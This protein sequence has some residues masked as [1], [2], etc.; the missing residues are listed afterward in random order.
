MRPPTSQC[1]GCQ[2]LQLRASGAR[3]WFPH[4]A[5]QTKAGEGQPSLAWQQGLFAAS[6]PRELRGFPTLSNTRGVSV[7][8][9]CT[10]LGLQDL[11][12]YGSATV[13]Q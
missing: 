6:S 2:L 7:Y 1:Q 8:S 12:N 3:G 5:S 13:Q 11:C 9:L 4:T 10:L